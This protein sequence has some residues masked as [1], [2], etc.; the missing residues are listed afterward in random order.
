MLFRRKDETEESRLIVA[1]DFDWIGTDELSFEML[2]EARERL[3]TPTAAALESAQ[4]GSVAVAP[5]LDRYPTVYAF[6]LHV[7]VCLL[8]TSPSPRDRG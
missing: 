7:Y 2:N 1:V 8:Y 3:F 6:L 4:A 5:L